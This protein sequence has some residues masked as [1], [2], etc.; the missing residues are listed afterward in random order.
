M[1]MHYII[2][3][4]LPGLG[5]VAGSPDSQVCLCT[6]YMPAP[7]AYGGSKQR[8]CGKQGLV[9]V[10]S[11]LDKLYNVLSTHYS[12]FSGTVCVRLT[13]KQD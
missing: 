7:T 11:M 8:F 5:D 4:P 6:P 12:I 13:V 2:S 9:L 10:I 1:T 3:G